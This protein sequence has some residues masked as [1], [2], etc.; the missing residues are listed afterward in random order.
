MLGKPINIA[1]RDR[2]GRYSLRESIVLSDGS[3]M[4]SSTHIKIITRLY[5]PIATV[6]GRINIGLVR[7]TMGL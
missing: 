3:R 6:V 2:C 4:F 1:M 7:K 5:S